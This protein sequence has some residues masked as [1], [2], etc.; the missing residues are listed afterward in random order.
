MNPNMITDL[1]Q[2]AIS[3]AETHA[4]GQDV[5]HILLAIVRKGVQAYEDQTGETL[6]PSLIRSENAI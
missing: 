2:L 3:L 5:A 1:V 6:N 4:A